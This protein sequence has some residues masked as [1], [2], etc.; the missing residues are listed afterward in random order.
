MNEEIF[1]QRSPINWG[2]R[3]VWNA[4]QCVDSKLISQSFSPKKCICERVKMKCFRRAFNPSNYNEIRPISVGQWILAAFRNGSRAQLKNWR[5]SYEGS[6]CLGDPLTPRF[7]DF[8]STNHGFEES[9]ARI[10]H[11]IELWIS[12]NCCWRS[13]L[14]NL[15]HCQIETEVI[16]HYQSS[17]VEDRPS[18]Q[19]CW[20]HRQITELN[21][22]V[23]PQ[24]KS[25]RWLAFYAKVK[26]RQPNNGTSSKWPQTITN[27][28]EWCQSQDAHLVA[29]RFCWI[30]QQKARHPN[31]IWIPDRV[32]RSLYVHSTPLF[33]TS[34][35]LNWRGKNVQHTKR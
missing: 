32:F 25:F 19:R 10:S 24:N 23:F 22:R 20:S 11:S 3:R 29:I 14:K 2:C 7:I 27:Q 1:Q 13:S 35:A 31:R 12:I 8:W 17:I 18:G 5:K 9:T 15:E 26:Q 4:H 30:R 21:E 33:V 34:I 6:C 28:T 16:S